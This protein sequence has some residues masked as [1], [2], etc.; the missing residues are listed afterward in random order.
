MG[1]VR[2][3]WFKVLEAD[4][5]DRNRSL[6]RGVV[7]GKDASLVEGSGLRLIVVVR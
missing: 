3:C 6:G 7:A 1:W 5:R 4:G 2:L